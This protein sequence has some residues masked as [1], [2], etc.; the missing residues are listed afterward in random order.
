MVAHVKIQEPESRLKIWSEFM[1]LFSRPNRRNRAGIGC[2]AAHFERHRGGIE[3]TS[4]SG[5]GTDVKISLPECMRRTGRMKETNRVL[6]VD[7]EE[8]VRVMLSAV[9]GK[10]AL[11]CSARQ[12]PAR[13]RGVQRVRS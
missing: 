1:T 9:L 4:E 6:V 11:R 10:E 5:I 2:G 12:W 3:I 13:P 7:D 8:S